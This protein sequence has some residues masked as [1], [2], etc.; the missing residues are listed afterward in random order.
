[1]SVAR[2]VKMV[3][4]AALGFQNVGQFFEPV[5]LSIH[6]GKRPRDVMALK[7]PVHGNEENG[8]WYDL[9]RTRLGKTLGIDGSKL[10]L[11]TITGREV[12]DMSASELISSGKL[13][14]Y[15]DGK[16]FVTERM[17]DNIPVEYNQRKYLTLA[18]WINDNVC[19]SE[20]LTQAIAGALVGKDIF[21]INKEILPGGKV[22]QTIREHLE[23]SAPSK[24]SS[25]P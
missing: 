3:N 7:V 15:V 18:K 12:R 13:H 24:F 20:E 11:K 16:R 22:E 8:R 25:L 21:Q 10:E 9:C 6:V 2:F 1:V 14:M 19:N 17:P 5:T 23:R 4:P